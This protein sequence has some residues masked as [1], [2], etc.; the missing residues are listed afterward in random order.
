[1]VGFP[2]FAK[3]AEESEE[4]A[5]SVQLWCIAAAEGEFIGLFSLPLWK[6]AVLC[7]VTLVEQVFADG[8]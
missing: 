4:E 6:E 1:M 7:S 2:C 8:F 5:Q 3:F